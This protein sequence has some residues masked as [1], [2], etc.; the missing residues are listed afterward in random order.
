[1]TRTYELG[2]IVEPRQSDEEVQAITERFVG[3]VEEGGSSV[4]YIDSWGKRKLAYPI[5]KFNEGRYVFL[6]VTAEEEPPPW[7]TV[8]RLMQQDEKIL[9]YLVVRTDHDLK[10]AFRKGKIKPE[11]PGTTTEADE[12]AEGSGDDTTAE[13]TTAD[14]SDV[15]PAEAKAAEAKPAK[16]EAA[17]AKPAETEAA[18][19]KP[20]KTEAAETQVAEGDAS[21]TESSDD[22]TDTGE[23]N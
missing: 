5:N 4:T 10:R 17:E 8:E 11:V 1:M 14:A 12:A 6:Y 20:V 16:T 23:E 19:A 7:P 22:S 9:R 2:F 13:A 15:K 3:L 18:E 21:E